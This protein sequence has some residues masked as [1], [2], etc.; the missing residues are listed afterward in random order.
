MAISSSIK[1]IN[2]NGGYTI[3][4]TRLL[5]HLITRDTSILSANR[6]FKHRH[7][8]NRCSP[9]CCFSWMSLLLARLSCDVSSQ[10]MSR[11]AFACLA[12]SEDTDSKH[13][14][15]KFQ[16]LTATTKVTN[17]GT[18]MI[19]AAIWDRSAALSVEGM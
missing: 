3:Q 19:N 4:H 9:L 1:C 15:H 14:I 6:G 18:N 8:N 17:I 5:I 10:P 7:P 12:Q 11:Y 13:I 2:H 16:Q